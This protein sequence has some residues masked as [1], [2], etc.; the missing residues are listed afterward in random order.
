MEVEVEQL[1]QARALAASQQTAKQMASDLDRAWAV[2]RRDSEVA[3]E[4]H[5]QVSSRGGKGGTRGRC[6]DGACRRAGRFH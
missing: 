1:Q 6:S 3:Q 4:R 2:Q 5:E